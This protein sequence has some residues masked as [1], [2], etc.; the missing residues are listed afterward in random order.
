MG[1]KKQVG[2]WAKKRKKVSFLTSQL[3][4]SASYL[5]PCELWKTMQRLATAQAL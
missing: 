3:H 1:G 2:E 5:M 4:R